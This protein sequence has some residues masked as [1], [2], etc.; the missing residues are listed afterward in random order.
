MK[1]FL[2]FAL[3]L[4]SACNSEHKDDPKPV[5]KPK[6]PTNGHLCYAD[7]SMAASRFAVFK[8]ANGQP[9]RWNK[10]IITFF[11]DK[12]LPDVVRPSMIECTRVWRAASG[13]LLTFNEVAKADNP[14]IFVTVMQD[15]KTEPYLGFTNFQLNPD[16]IKSSRIEINTNL[17][18]WHRGAP[19]GVGPQIGTAK[20]DTDIDGVMLHELGHALGLNHATDRASTM[21]PTIFPGAETIEVDDVKGLRSIYGDGAK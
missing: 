9:V 5:V 19:Y 8:F 2:C 10:T 11:V 15:L 1:R 12:A 18:R 3:L 21:Y 7:E 4:L 14:D 20:R 17:Y 13:G 6:I 16:S